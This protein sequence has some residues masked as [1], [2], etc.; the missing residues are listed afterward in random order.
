MPDL[1]TIGRALFGRAWQ[2][3]LAEGIGVSERTMRYWVAGRPVPPGAWQDMAA[4]ARER[5]DSLRAIA[6]SIERA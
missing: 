2:R 5:A 1:P 3:D 6:D 4:L